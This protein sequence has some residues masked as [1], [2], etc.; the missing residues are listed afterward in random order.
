[1]VLSITCLQID[2][3]YLC[4]Q[5]PSLA[6][7]VSRTMSRNWDK[8][9]IE[10][11]SK[12]AW[13]QVKATYIFT[14]KQRTE[15][16]DLSPEKCVNA[17]LLIFIK[18]AWIEKQQPNNTHTHAERTS[19]LKGEMLLSQIFIKTARIKKKIKSAVDCSLKTGNRNL[20]NYCMDFFIFFFKAKNNN[21]NNR[22]D[23]FLENGNASFSKTAWT[24]SKYSGQDLFQK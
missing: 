2:L 24:E 9:I 19:P 1:M 3:G 8:D 14:H 6:S 20:H 17:S 16:T 22:V 12:N 23:H 7:V 21:N 10:R 15:R 13:M 4:L 18:T 11:L 5:F